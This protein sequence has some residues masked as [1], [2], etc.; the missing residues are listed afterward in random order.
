MKL[1]ATR[2]GKQ[3][4][5]VLAACLLL[6]C[7]LAGTAGGA[8]SSL[9]D[10]EVILAQDAAEGLDLRTAEGKAA[11]VR[12]DPSVPGRGKAGADGQE[13]DYTGL[14]GY[15]ALEENP[16]DSLFS[17]YDKA[18][19]TVPL[20]RKTEEGYTEQGATAHKTPVVVTG[21]EL[22]PDGKGGFS[23]YLEVIRL[24]NGDSCALKAE[25]F[26]TLPYW[27]LEAG[28]IPA[29]GF[30]IA[31]YRE[32]PGTGPRNANGEACMIRDGTRV[33]IPPESRV[34]GENPDPA[35]LQVC[36]VVFR[37]ETDG[38]IRQNFVYFRDRDLNPNY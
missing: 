29:Y 25:C 8:G 18:Y 3:K 19:W 1:Y 38:S 32:T 36:A 16:A 30:S 28:E 5:R 20:F 26:V 10:L 12:K 14:V 9:P 13:P 4:T 22:E 21:Q 15:A 17:L 11:T 23:G 24:D 7:L 37:E 34:S 31:V 6:I 35:H 33:L 27:T 2:Q